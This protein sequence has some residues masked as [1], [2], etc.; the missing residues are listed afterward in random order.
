MEL[1]KTMNQY[2]LVNIENIGRMV[3]KIASGEADCFICPSE[4]Q[5][6][7]QNLCAPDALMR[8]MGGI[9][10]RID[11]ENPDEMSKME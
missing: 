1:F 9:I 5:Y 11:L 2:G 10:T 4:S 7:V 8:A 3:S 6:Q